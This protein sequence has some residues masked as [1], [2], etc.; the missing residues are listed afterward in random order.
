MGGIVWDES[1]KRENCGLSD[2]GHFHRGVAAFFLFP[3]FVNRL[4]IY[5]VRGSQGAGKMRL[6]GF[7]AALSAFLQ[8]R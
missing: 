2:T 3:S 4:F 1:P 7:R 5:T 6:V 8:P